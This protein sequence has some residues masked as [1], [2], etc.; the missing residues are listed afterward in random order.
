MKRLI[1]IYLLKLKNEKMKNKIVQII[2]L[3]FVI[4]SCKKETSKTIQEINMDGNFVKYNPEIIN[5]F[6]HKNFQKSDAFLIQ[7][8]QVM[9]ARNKENQSYFAP[10]LV[11]LNKQNKII[12]EAEGTDDLF[13]YNP[14]FFI[15]KDKKQVIIC[16][17]MAYEYNIGMDIFLIENNTI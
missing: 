7:D 13:Q 10:H 12:F 9:I 6:R 11:A 2:I 17:Q 3:L 14:H 8:L 5:N 16:I 1:L 4:I 15:S